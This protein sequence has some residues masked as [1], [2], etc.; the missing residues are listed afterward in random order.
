M[1]YNSGVAPGVG[2]GAI[3]FPFGSLYNFISGHNGMPVGEFLTINCFL[4]LSKIP[5][6]LLNGLLVGEPSPPVRQIMALPLISLYHDRL[7]RVEVDK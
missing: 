6:V 5:S 1:T 4:L 3:T 2:R 7:T